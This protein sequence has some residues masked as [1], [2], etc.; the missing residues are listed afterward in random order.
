VNQRFGLTSSSG[1]KIPETS[2]DIRTTRRY[3]SEDG[4]NLQ[5]DI[6]KLNCELDSTS[7]KR[8]QIAGLLSERLGT[9]RLHTSQPFPYQQSYLEMNPYHVS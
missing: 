3:I 2:V 8:G 6:E 9:S 4:N 7:S 1:S 5:T